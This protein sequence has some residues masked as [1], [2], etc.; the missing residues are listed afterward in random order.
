MTKTTSQ[1]S[2][3]FGSLSI[4]T[5]GSFCIVMD[6]PD[7]ESSNSDSFTIKSQNSAKIEILS[8]DIKPSMNFEFEINVSLLDQN[9]QPYSVESDI[10]ITLI[11]NDSS[12]E[13]QSLAISQSLISFLVTY[14]NFGYLQVTA[15][16]SDPGIIP[17]VKVI[18]VMKNIL[19]VSPIFIVNS[20]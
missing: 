4:S 18:E 9:N 19:V 3:I 16:S 15:S 5:E 8:P 14:K 13:S 1:A 12:I 17:Q 11:F 6:C 2:V 10:I 7:A 20:I